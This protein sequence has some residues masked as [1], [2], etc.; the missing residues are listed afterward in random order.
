MLFNV[1]IFGSE[2]DNPED[3]ITIT[4]RVLKRANQV[5]SM[6]MKHKVLSDFAHILKVL[7]LK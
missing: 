4:F 6:V 3:D 5:L 1:A 2:V 7:V